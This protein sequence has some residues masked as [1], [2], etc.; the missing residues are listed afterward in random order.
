MLFYIRLKLDEILKDEEYLKMNEY[1]KI[2]FG[3]PINENTYNKIYDL[4][5]KKV[6]DYKIYFK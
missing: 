3:L 2:K 4:P 1:D 5:E 6:K